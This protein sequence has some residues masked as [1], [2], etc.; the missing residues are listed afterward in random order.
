VPSIDDNRG[1]WTDFPWREHGDEWS[2]CWGSSR[3]L[4][5]GTLLPRIATDLPTEHVLEIAPG[6]GRIT[7]FLLPLCT[8]YTGVD[9]V[10][11]C[12]AHCRTRFADA[13][14]ATFV[15]NDGRSLEAVADASVDFAISWD[16][17]VH[18]D[19]TVLEAYVAELARTL[20]PGARAFLHHSNLGAW[21]E[22]DGTVPIP[23]PHWR[24][25]SVDA[26]LVRAAI[27][28]NGLICVAQ[29]LVQWSTP[30]AQDAFTMLRRS[31]PGEDPTNA[32]PP[33]VTV[34]PSFVAEMEHFRRIGE[35]YGP[36]S[37]A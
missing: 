13:A 18:A 22:P 15:R 23:N 30:D 37:R 36:S 25:P 16:S 4:W 28:K 27:R 26:A 9:L 6:H 3:M 1:A 19:I 12:V 7:Q 14:H 32:R 20:R 34:H 8:R 24:D 5:Q 11:D 17:L 31:A 35:S 2:V 29:E 33:V 10:D 21:R